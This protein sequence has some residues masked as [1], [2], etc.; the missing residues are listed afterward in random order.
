MAAVEGGVTFWGAWDSGLTTLQR[1]SN[2]CMAGYLKVA[3]TVKSNRLL[4][5]PKSSGKCFI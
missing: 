5:Y 3:G 4:R 1:N 2:Q